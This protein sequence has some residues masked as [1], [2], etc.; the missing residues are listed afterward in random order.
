MRGPCVGAPAAGAAATERPAFVAVCTR[1][2]AARIAVGVDL[3]A[4]ESGALLLIAEDV[5][6]AA[7]LLK[8]LLGSGIAALRVRMVLLGE[9]T[10]RLLDLGFACLLAHAQNFVRITHDV[11]RRRKIVSRG[12]LQYGHLTSAVKDRRSSSC[13]KAVAPACFQLRAK[14]V[15]VGGTGKRANPQTVPRPFSRQIG[16]LDIRLKFRHRSVSGLVGAP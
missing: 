2:E 5:I 6:G 11:S 10:K 3:A 1:I 15:S 8:L 4:V 13:G 12:P 7:D 9:R 16:P 14:C